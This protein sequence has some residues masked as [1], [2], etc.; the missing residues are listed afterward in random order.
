MN[1][2]A[3]GIEEGAGQSA[4]CRITG[5]EIDAMRGAEQDKRQGR[6][7]KESGRLLTLNINTR[8]PPGFP[9]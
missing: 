3:S 2:R 8:P 9:E 1:R 4:G 7:R 5:M 6:Y